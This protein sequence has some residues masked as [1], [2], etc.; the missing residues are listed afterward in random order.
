M[1]QKCIRWKAL[2]LLDKVKRGQ[3]YVMF[4]ITSPSSWSLDA[5]RAAN[6]F[7][8]AKTKSSLSSG[9]YTRKIFPSGVI[10]KENLKKK[11]IRITG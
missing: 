11:A 6:P 4:I 2:K 5:R 10:S 9:W 3:K 1:W 7:F 8:V